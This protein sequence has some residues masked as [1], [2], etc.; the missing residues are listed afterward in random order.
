MYRYQKP[1]WLGALCL[2]GLVGAGAL[3]GL[4]WA[5][6]QGRLN[7]IAGATLVLLLLGGVFLALMAGS[8]LGALPKG[9]VTEKMPARE[10]KNCEMID[11]RFAKGLSAAVLLLSGVLFLGMYIQAG[12]IQS[13]PR[14]DEIMGIYYARAEVL[15]VEE[16][17]YERDEQMED[18]AIG[19]QM[20]RV[21]VETGP[22]EGREFT[23]KNYLSYFYGTLLKPGDPVTISFTEAKEGEEPIV[24]VQDYDRTIPLAIVVL[25]F[26]IC[27]VLVGGKVGAKSLLGLGFTVLCIFTIMIPQMIAGAPTLPTVLM[28]CAF[29]TVVTFVILD[30]VNRKTICAIF[31]TILGVCVSAVFGKFAC[32]L[33][34][35][36]GFS[37]FDI[38]TAIEFL[39]QIKQGQVMGGAMSSMQLS[40]MLVGGILIAALGAV[41]D[42]AMSIS[43]AMNELIAV[44]PELSRRELIK[45]GMNIG[46]DMVGTM[47]NTLILAFVGSG[48]VTIIYLCSLEPTFRQFMSTTY[49]SVEMVQVLASSLGVIVG[50][51]LS[52]IL[53]ALLFGKRGSKTG[54]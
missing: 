5:G 40:D 47:T 13:G 46:R 32:W 38:D 48:M 35:I 26:L 28:I 53:G 9:S 42:V 15:S 36:S 54:A 17:A 10:R 6:T 19:H 30:G 39:L 14:S 20:L 1:V 22:L 44:N 41:N 31:G 16:D 4:V 21:R 25:M 37:V 33:L 50:V 27:T 34:R 2:G 23:L 43:S 8:T 51:P 7:L 45:S 18:V 24:L 12:G 29:V 52:V 49:L 11:R 3:A